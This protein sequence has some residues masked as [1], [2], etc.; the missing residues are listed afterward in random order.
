MFIGIREFT[1][2]CNGDSETLLLCCGLSTWRW[3]DGV[4]LTGAVLLMKHRIQTV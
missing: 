1:G 3:L 2:W 4:D